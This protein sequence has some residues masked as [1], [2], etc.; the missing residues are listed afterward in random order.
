MGQL[1]CLKNVF[2]YFLRKNIML[3]PRKTH[4]FSKIKKK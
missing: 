4:E 2:A 1:D 3:V